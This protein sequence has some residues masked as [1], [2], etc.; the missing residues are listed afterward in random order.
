MDLEATPLDSIAQPR[1]CVRCSKPCLL[2]VVGRCADCMADMYFNHPE[3]Y[4]AFKDDVR[5]E[6]G[7]K[8]IA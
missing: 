3:D 2:W 6:F 8:A 4:R 5:E 7:T 1:P